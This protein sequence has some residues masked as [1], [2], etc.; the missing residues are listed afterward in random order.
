MV[1]M[2]EEEFTTC[3]KEKGVRGWSL[4]Q[5]IP[6]QVM[7]DHRY[8]FQDVVVFGRLV[9]FKVGFHVNGRLLDN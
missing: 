9:P 2:K 8:I 4:E 7:D 6:L 3:P 5:G 1:L